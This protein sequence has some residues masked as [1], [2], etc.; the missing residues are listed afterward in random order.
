[1][2]RAGNRTDCLEFRPMPFNLIIK[3]GMGR[4]HGWVKTEQVLFLVKSECNGGSNDFL[5]SALG[6]QMQ[7]N[8]HRYLV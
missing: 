5:S 3:E 4:P 8:Y 7:L 1:M 6:K 2:G